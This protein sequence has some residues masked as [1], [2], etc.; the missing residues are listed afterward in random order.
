V[1]AFTRLSGR[2]ESSLVDPLAR[3]G[4]AAVVGDGDGD[5]GREIEGVIEGVTAEWSASERHVMMTAAQNEGI[6]V[7]LGINSAERMLLESKMR[8][9]LRCRSAEC[10]VQS[11]E[12]AVGKRPG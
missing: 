10:R 7:R 9:R 2:S 8:L 5:G 3:G 6:C 12:R 11:A 1:V 4:E